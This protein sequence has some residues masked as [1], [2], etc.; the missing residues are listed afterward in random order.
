M[1]RC[2]ECNK[3]VSYDEIEAELGSDSFREG[4][5]C[6]GVRLML[7]CCE[8]GEE[9][10]EAYL[11]LEAD[12]VCPNCNST[13]VY[14]QN[15]LGEKVPII[16]D[17]VDG[18]NNYISSHDTEFFEEGE[19]ILEYYDSDESEHFERFGDIKPNGKVVNIRKKH[20]YGAE[21]C[22]HFHCKICG[23]NFEVKL[24]DEILSIDMDDLT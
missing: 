11:E 2:P 8:C 16:N 20:Y 23:H 21:V 13:G 9:L 22:S 1:A 15:D 24:S 17:I 7:P 6:I 12:V 5:L 14:H 3:F 18:Q 19:E 4:H 10:K